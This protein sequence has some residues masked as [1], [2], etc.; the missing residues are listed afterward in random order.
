[1]IM[2][3]YRFL[4]LPILLLFLL[5]C[6]KQQQPPGTSSLTIVNGVVATQILIP[7]FNGATP[8]TWFGSANQ[9]AYATFYNTSSS[10]SNQL[11]SYSGLQHLALYNSTDTL[12]K[13][14]PIFDLKLNLAVDSIYSLFLTG[15]LSSPDTLFIRETIP[16]H[17]PSDSAA[18]IRFINLSPGSAPISVNI[19][20]QAYGSQVSSLSYKGVTGFIS[21]PATAGNSS[22][23]FEFRD[24]VSGTFLASYQANGIDGS[25]SG[26][27]YIPGNG[28]IYKNNT[29]AL[30]GVPNGANDSAQMVLLVNNY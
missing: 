14:H 11:N 18:W 3:H 13:S 10:K 1:M 9:L 24:A 28:W 6:S 21:Y 5:S 19:Q 27:G 4:Q 16:Y 8:L 25:V 20:G 22:Y 29:L 26:P 15:T 12:P 30:L 2:T 23:T 7:D 17:A